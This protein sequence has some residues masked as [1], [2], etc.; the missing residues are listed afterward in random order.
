MKLGQY[1][2]KIYCIG[3]M[4]DNFIDGFITGGMI[5]FCQYGRVGSKK[6]FYKHLHAKIS[7]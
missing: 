4:T 6:R 5:T 3:P 1:F 7:K 2:L